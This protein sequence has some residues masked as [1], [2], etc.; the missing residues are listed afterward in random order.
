L[1]KCPLFSL[2]LLHLLLDVLHVLD[3]LL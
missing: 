2:L 3:L 1:L